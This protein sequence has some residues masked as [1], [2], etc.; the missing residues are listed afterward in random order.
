MNF[1]SE[2]ELEVLFSSAKITQFA[3]EE[4]GPSCD[5]RLSDQ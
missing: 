1:V 4:K 5:P 3:G 2:L